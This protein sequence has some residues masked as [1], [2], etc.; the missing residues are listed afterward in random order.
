MRGDIDVVVEKYLAYIWH[1][2]VFPSLEGLDTVLAAL[3]FPLFS[4]RVGQGA[5]LKSEAPLLAG[6]GVLF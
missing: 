5:S 4:R 6:S 3:S 1:G 2:I